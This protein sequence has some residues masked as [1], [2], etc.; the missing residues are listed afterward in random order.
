MSTKFFSMISF[1]VLTAAPAFGQLLS[2]PL[3]P[4][5][6]DYMKQRHTVGLRLIDTKRMMVDAAHVEWVSKEQITVSAEVIDMR[7]MSIEAQRSIMR[8]VESYNNSSSVG[9]LAVVDGTKVRMTHFLNPT[10]TS[11]SRIAGTIV[12][13]GTTVEE[14]KKELTSPVV[15]EQPL[16]FIH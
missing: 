1:L 9:T 13:F 8:R 4:G 10:Q 16:R 12:D 6:Y 5:L 7:G 2:S 11:F 14:L 15:V 3:E